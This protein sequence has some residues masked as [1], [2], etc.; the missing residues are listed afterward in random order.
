MSSALKIGD[1]ALATFLSQKMLRHYHKIGLLVPA[2]VDSTTGYRSY[3]AEQI[4]TAQII[5]RLRDMDMPL[6][7][8][9]DVLTA[10]D[11][12]VRGQLLRAHLGSLEAALARTTDAVTSLRQLLDVAPV[13]SAVVHRHVPSTPAAMVTS[14]VDLMEALGWVYGAIG[15]LTATLSAQSIAQKSDPVGV[16][17]SELFGHERGVATVFV[18][19]DPLPRTAGRIATTIMPEVDLAVIDHIGTH[20]DIDRA[21]GTLAEYVSRHAIGIEGT[22]YERYIVGPADTADSTQWRTEVGWP[23]FRTGVAAR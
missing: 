12:E 13:A 6:Q 22:I 11:I 16:F 8:I 10:P 2:Q 20:A 7:L 14:T 21:Y 15:E 18:P 5:R 3:T 4:P 9:R 17:S 1:F 19:C 23:I